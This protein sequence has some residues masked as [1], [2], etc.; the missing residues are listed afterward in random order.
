M[1][2][3]QLRP[4]E[5]RLARLERGMR[6]WRGLALLLG[7][8]ILAALARGAAGPS[9]DLVRAKRIELVNDQ[10]GVTAVLESDLTG[11]LLRLYTHEGREHIRLV[12]TGAGGELEI[13]SPS[14]HS[15]VSLYGGF[16]AG[17]V[18]IDAG[19]LRIGSKN[20]G[21]TTIMGRTLRA[22]D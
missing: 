3:L 19:L 8:A 6:F 21:S 9:A 2:S 20:L 16:L 17:M 22:G 18:R 14:G 12:T 1:T 11:G 10:G 15:L 5:N 7:L 4:L 13:T